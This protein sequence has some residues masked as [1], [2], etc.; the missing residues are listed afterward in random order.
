MV[1]LLIGGFFMRIFF[2]SIILFVLIPSFVIADFVLPEYKILNE[3][4]YEK[5]GKAQVIL[6]ILVSGKI[7]E[8]NLKALLNKLYAS[9]SKKTG[10]KYHKHP[11]VIGIYVYTS[12]E[13]AKHSIGFWI[14]K[15]SKTPS[16]TKPKIKL[17]KAQIKHLAKIPEKKFKL[18][19]T[20]RKLILSELVKVA[21]VKY[22]IIEDKKK[23][24]IKRSVV[25][26]LKKKVRKKV[27]ETIAQNIKQ[28]DSRL[29]QRTFISYIV[30]GQSKK[31]GYWATTYFNPNIEVKIFRLSLEE[32]VALTKKPKQTPG[33]KIIGSWL[34]DRANVG[35][36]MTL[37]YENRT[38]FLELSYPGG[39]S[40]VE[41]KVEYSENGGRRIDDKD[42]NDFGEYFFI[43]Q[44]ND[45]EFWDKN[46]N[47]Y[48]ARK[49]P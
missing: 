11:T 20:K 17:K 26:L 3:D 43:N 27:L 22:N 9:V 2:S 13:N 6:D 44:N 41:E 5:P 36:R 42:G 1:R 39:S 40:R 10:F 49:L 48:T 31:D 23:R 4:I 18:P 38:L 47:Y 45:L 15:L 35:A 14:G 37:F 28:G 30:E 32:E 21:D 34:D 7:T 8:N 46:G 25:V 33:R 16:D 29:Y 24:D 19:E 12:E